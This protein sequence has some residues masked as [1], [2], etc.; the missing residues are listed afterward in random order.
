M[1]I[2]SSGSSATLSNERKENQHKKGKTLNNFDHL[3]RFYHSFS[4]WFSQSINTA[5]S[6]FTKLIAVANAQSPKTDNTIESVDNLKVDNDADDDDGS[7]GGGGG[8]GGAD[9]DDDDVAKVNVDCEMSALNIA[10]NDNE[11]S[12]KNVLPKPMSR[13]STPLQAKP[14]QSK[15]MTDF[16]PVRRRSVRKTKK[17]VEQEY[18]RNIEKAI[19][20]QSEDGLVVKLFKDKGRGIC[21]GRPFARGEF[22]V[23][24]IG[25]LIEQAEADRR[26]EIY[27]KDTAFG[28]YMYYFKH[29][30]QQWW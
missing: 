21:A 11:T 9:D 8:G 4:F 22:V 5:K 14:M 25:D 18:L 7:G 29:K 30:E 27:A 1:R 2:E 3:I 24:Y 17:A 20:Q 12:M 26:E 28:C 23:E 13:S 15:Q 10:S 19:E 16:Y 6:Y